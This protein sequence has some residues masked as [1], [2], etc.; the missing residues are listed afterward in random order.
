M[1]GFASYGPK[2]LRVNPTLTR[3]WSAILFDLD[4]TITDS[5]PAITN[6]LARTF[7]LLGR[8]V[9][10]DTELMAYVGPPLLAAFGEPFL[11]DQG[12]GRVL[13][14]GRGVFGTL[15]LREIGIDRIENSRSEGKGELFFKS[16]GDLQVRNASELRVDRPHAGLRLFE[17]RVPR[18]C[19]I[20]NAK[21]LARC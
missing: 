14:A 12:I 20:G 4:G 3:T 7:A 11:G 16:V 18:V 6:S 13:F 8:P 1:Q 10:S 2:M 5:A 19:R 9:P 21:R 17:K 15:G